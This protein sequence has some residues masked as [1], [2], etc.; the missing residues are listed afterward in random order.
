[1]VRVGRLLLCCAALAWPSVGLGEPLGGT[2]DSREA[3]FVRQ[4]REFMTRMA[5]GNKVDARKIAKS[6]GAAA[7][8]DAL[9][10][11]DSLAA[12][13][14]AGHVRS[15]PGGASMLRVRP[16]VDGAHPIGEFDLAHQSLY[17]AAHPAAIECLLRI[18]ASMREGPIEV[19]SLVRHR[20][21][22]TR[23]ARTNVNATRSGSLHA[24]GLAFDISVLNV[25]SSV[26]RQLGDLLLEMRAAGDLY[27]I[28]ETRQLVFHIVPTPERLNEYADVTRAMTDVGEPRIL[29]TAPRQLRLPSPAP[30][31][32]DMNAAS[33]TVVPVGQALV[34]L[35]V[36][37]G[38]RRLR[39][40]RL[41]HPRNGAPKR[42][43]R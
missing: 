28:A 8:S 22:Q 10:D 3:Q 7:V 5:T 25:P 41:P 21:Y 39:P 38:V 34:T 9:P 24:L 40:P 11:R 32:I 23:L 20:E 18:A 2:A 42:V 6:Y 33:A 14:G 27:F 15:L 29:P 36:A 31:I 35:L 43:G 26:A 30:W 4:T 1:M 13:I 12:A 16:R 19:T 37:A 17:L